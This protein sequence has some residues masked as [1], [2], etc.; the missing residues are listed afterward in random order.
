MTTWKSIFSD[1]Q[2]FWIGMKHTIE[3][4]FSSHEL[5]D[6]VRRPEK[7]DSDADLARSNFTS[8]FSP[9]VLIEFTGD[10]LSQLFIEYGFQTFLSLFVPRLWRGGTKKKKKIIKE[11]ERERRRFTILVNDS[12]PANLPV[13]AFTHQRGIITRE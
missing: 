11:R 7:Y 12:R 6:F 8:E 10:R 5:H 3:F 1:L 9:A 13:A 2:H 4:V